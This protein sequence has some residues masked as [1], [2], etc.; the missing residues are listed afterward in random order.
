[1]R[2]G[3]A[4]ADGSLAVTVPARVPALALSLA[5][6]ATGATTI[7]WRTLPPPAPGAPAR[8]EVVLAVA[9]TVGGVPV[10]LTTELDGTSGWLLRL[11]PGDDALSLGA[12]LTQLARLLHVDASR[13]ALPPQLSP[14]LDLHLIELAAVVRISPPA[15]TA[16]VVTVGSGATWPL[17]IPGV[18][19]GGLALTW[20]LDVA[21]GAL[22]PGAATVAAALTLAPPRG[23][24]AAPAVFDLW[25]EAPA[26]AVGARLRAGTEL[27]L[28][29]VLASLA[30]TAEVALPPE[31]PALRLDAMFFA[32]D[33]SSGAVDASA[34]LVVDWA[35]PGAP[36]I[37]A[38]FG[39]A[40]SRTPTGDGGHALAGQV[41]VDARGPIPIV[42]GVS[43]DGLTLLF[44]WSEGAAW[45]VAGSV[46]ATVFGHAVE[47]AASYTDGAA[48]RELTL[49]ATGDVE[50]ALAGVGSLRLS[51]LSFRWA[52]GGATGDAWA[53]SAAASL[54]LDGLATIGGTLAIADD[55]GARSLT[56]TPTPGE[57]ALT[58]ALPLP[59]PAPELGLRLDSLAIAHDATAGWSIAASGGLTLTGLAEAV[60]RYLPARVDA[61]LTVDHTGVAVSLPHL[62]GPLEIPLPT[63]TLGSIAIPLGTAAV[64]VGALTARL[65]KRF[66]VSIE[67]GIGLPAAINDVFGTRTVDGEAAPRQMAV[68]YAACDPRARSA[69]ASRSTTPT[70]LP[71]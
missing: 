24:T 51:E 18:S 44:A 64:D 11:V 30:G 58:L 55:A 4:A 10:S 19:I 53:V 66:A 63:A 47:L 37:E 27:D 22:S 8:S 39:V 36:A 23:S 69:G 41:G 45:T 33:P 6:L 71:L 54:A 7:E 12:G 60:Q 40:V 46:A 26:Y 5:P 32:A 25:A 57:D 65:G 61:S 20:E 16:L 67:L 28:G 3:A 68:T 9:M 70:G 56:L 42:G 15:L 43:L 21:G 38:A 34:G 1:M 17:P 62:V 29:A 49:R 13:L 14:A 2:I 48:G 59:G 35:L 31:L 52:R 50:L